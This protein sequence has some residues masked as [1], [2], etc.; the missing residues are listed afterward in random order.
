MIHIFFITMRFS[1]QAIPQ[2]LHELES[3]GITQLQIFLCPVKSN[4]LF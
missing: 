3:D 2:Q 4:T 1:V